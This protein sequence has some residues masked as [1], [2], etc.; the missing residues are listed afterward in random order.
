MNMNYELAAVA[1]ATLLT[2]MGYLVKCVYRQEAGIARLQGGLRRY[3][4]R[5]QY[6]TQEIS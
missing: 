1:M 2:G 4:Q 5:A 6:A 3:M